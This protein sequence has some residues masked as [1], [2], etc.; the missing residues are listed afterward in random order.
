MFKLTEKLPTLQVAG[1]KIVLLDY[2]F[3]CRKNEQGLL[4]P[5]YKQVG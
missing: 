1:H 2:C 4:G 3:Y 5:V